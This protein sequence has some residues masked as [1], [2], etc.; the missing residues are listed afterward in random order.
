[1]RKPVAVPVAASR[2]DRSTELVCLALATALVMLAVRIV[3]VF[4]LW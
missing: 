1:M 3:S 2:T 4:S